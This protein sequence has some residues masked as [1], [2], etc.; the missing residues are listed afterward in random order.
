MSMQE[1]GLYKKHYIFETLHDKITW[2]D[3]AQPQ[4][5]K[6]NF[7]FMPYNKRRLFYFFMC[8]P[9]NWVKPGKFQ[10]SQKRFH[11]ILCVTK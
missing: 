10:S 1:F 7:L 9:L 2:Q 3:T 11:K 6:K 5:F 4:N 8:I